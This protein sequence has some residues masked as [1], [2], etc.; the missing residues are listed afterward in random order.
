MKRRKINGKVEK[1]LNKSVASVNKKFGP[2]SSRKNVKVISIFPSPAFLRISL[3]NV[4]LKKLS[5]I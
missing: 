4:K 3:T 1:I 5:K 2:E